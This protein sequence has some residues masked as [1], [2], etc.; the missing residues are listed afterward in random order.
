MMNC[1]KNLSVRSRVLSSFAVVL[2]VSGSLGLFALSQLKDINQITLEINNKIVP[3]LRYI[4][5][6]STAS[7]RLRSQ[8]GITMLTK[9]NDQ[10]DGLKKRIALV[11]EKRQKVWETLGALFQTNEERALYDEAGRLWAEYVDFGNRVLDIDRAGGHDEAVALLNGDLQK[12]MDRYRKSFIALSEYCLK[13]SQE[14]AAQSAAVYAQTVRDIVGFLFGAL[15]LCLLAGLNIITNVSRPISQMI[16]VMRKLAAHNME[17]E[18]PGQDRKDEI[19][20]MARAIQVFKDNMA[21]TARLNEQTL[22]ERKAREARAQKIEG[23]TKA[24]GEKIAALVSSLGGAA[25]DLRHTASS[26]KDVA[27]GTNQRSIVVASAAEEASSSVQTVASAAEQLA[28]SISEISRQVT[29]SSDMAQAASTGANQANDIV[30][31]LAATA[32]KIGSIVEMINQIASQT[33]LL[34][35]NATIEAAR[36]GEAGKGFA[37]V[38]SEVKSLANQ[39]GKATEEIAAQIAQIQQATNEV[40]AS[41]HNIGDKIDGINRVSETIASSIK[42]QQSATQEIAGTIQQTAAGTGEV[43]ENIVKVREASAQTGSAAQ[44]V[45]SA[46]DALA[47]KTNQLSSEVETF[48]LSVKSV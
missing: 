28:S 35:L 3:S 24:F 41:I 19:G 48:I 31:N 14:K 5:D 37:V 1:C 4:G 44:E 12:A 6:L 42:E 20:G 34:A 33:N 16:E 22:A 43:S 26:M 47:E 8:Q 36:A 40:V 2:L 23:M 46:A 10:K 25:G 27:E 38:A 30:Q 29:N 32:D 7:E 18:I 11:Q 15:L 39:T 9:D 45:L 17:T 13:K 21:E